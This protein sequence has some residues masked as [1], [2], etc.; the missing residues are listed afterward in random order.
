MHRTWIVNPDKSAI[1]IALGGG[2]FEIPEMYD[3]VYQGHKVRIHCGGGGMQAKSFTRKPD[4]SI[5][6]TIRVTEMQ[7]P[8]AL[9]QDQHAVFALMAEAFAVEVYGADVDPTLLV[10]VAF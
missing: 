4:Q 2:S 7:M 8:P 9:E 1:L 10:E 3:F 6:V 5:G